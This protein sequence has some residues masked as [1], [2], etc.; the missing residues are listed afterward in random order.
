MTI[1]CLVLPA[2]PACLLACLASYACLLAACWLAGFACLAACLLA[3]LASYACLQSPAGWLVLP[4]LHDQLLVCFACI[5]C[6]FVAHLASNACLLATCCMVSW[7]CQLQ[8]A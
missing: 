7:F 1:Y 4:A 2:M 5:A 8:Y 3:Y 6:L